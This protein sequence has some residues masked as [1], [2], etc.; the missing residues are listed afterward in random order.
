M[1]YKYKN[2]INKAKLINLKIICKN[3]NNSNS[4]AN[5]QFFI[6]II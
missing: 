5:T 6:I 3:N 2:G 1:Y 4:D